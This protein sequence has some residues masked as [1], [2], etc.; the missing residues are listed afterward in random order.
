MKIGDIIILTVIALWLI[1]A[2]IWAWK[3][4]KAGKCIGCS[5]CDS[6]ACSSCP[7]KK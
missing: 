6:G 7:K 5:A 2:L 4:K 1:A 3:R